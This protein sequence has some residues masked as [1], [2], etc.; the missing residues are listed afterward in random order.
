MMNHKGTKYLDTE[1]LVLRQFTCEDIE[2]SYNNWTSD[3]K[4]VQ[5]LTWP[6]HESV[7]VTKMVIGNWINHYSEPNFYQWAIVLKET[8]EVIGTISAVGMDEKVDMVRIGYCIGS[9]WWRNGYVSE[10]FARI[11]S[12]FFE[13]VGVKRL[14]ARH[15]PF[16]GASGRVME[17]CG[18]SYEGTLRQA[19]YNNMGIVDACIYS[20]LAT[21]YFSF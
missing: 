18:L 5:Y 8:N 19:D 20:I 10:A 6:V 12:Y 15:D 16:N 2:P 17:K 14:E 4:V 13:E 7:E 21:E 9:K 3:E 11:I 1:R